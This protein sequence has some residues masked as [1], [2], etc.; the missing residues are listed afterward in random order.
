MGIGNIPNLYG[1]QLV[2]ASGG[3]SSMEWPQTPGPF[4]GSSSG[5]LKAQFHCGF[6]LPQMP[7]WLNSGYSRATHLP[8]HCRDTQSVLLLSSVV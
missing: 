8:Y 5:G 3:M 7:K 4:K 2:V 1:C 6:D